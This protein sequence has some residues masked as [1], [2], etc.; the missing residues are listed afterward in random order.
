[1]EMNPIS[2]SGGASSNGMFMK[3]LEGVVK[4]LRRLSLAF[5]DKPCDF[6]KVMAPYV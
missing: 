2:T 5:V 6:A 3:L 4:G 1:M